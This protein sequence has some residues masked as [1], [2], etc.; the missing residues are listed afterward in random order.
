M[1]RKKKKKRTEKEREDL[2]IK[3]QKSF[4][5]QKRDDRHNCYLGSVVLY[6]SKKYMVVV[7]SPLFVFL[8]N[9]NGVKRLTWAKWDNGHELSTRKVKWCKEIRNCIRFIKSQLKEEA[10]RRKN[11]ERNP[12]IKRTPIKKKKE[13]AEVSIK[14]KKLM[15]RRNK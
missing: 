5:A 13:I 12:K 1:P 7:T 14:K 15:K 11:I 4:L 8:A 2:Y 3:K 9:K 6:N 10:L